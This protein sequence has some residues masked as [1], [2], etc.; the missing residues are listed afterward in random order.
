MVTIRPDVTIRTGWTIAVSFKDST[1]IV[2]LVEGVDHRCMLFV[3]PSEDSIRRR[4]DLTER[5]SG[6]QDCRRVSVLNR[7]YRSQTSMLNDI[8]N[9]GRMNCRSCNCDAALRPCFGDNIPARSPTRCWCAMSSPRQH[10][11]ATRLCHPKIH[12]LASSGANYWQRFKDMLRAAGSP[13]TCAI[14][15]RRVCSQ[16]R[17][18]PTHR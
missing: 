14:G 17:A 1:N 3:R 15:R 9:A 18:Q 13:H 2:R 4:L 6:I 16:C 12:M 11:I 8:C 5:T 10:L 7:R